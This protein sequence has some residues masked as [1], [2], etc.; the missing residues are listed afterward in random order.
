MSLGIW[1]FTQKH[2]WKA[3]GGSDSDWFGLWRPGVENK[4][5]GPGPCGRGCQELQARG[6]QACPPH[7]L[8]PPTSMNSPLQSSP[9]QSPSLVPPLSVVLGFEPRTSCWS[10]SSHS[11]P[12]PLHA[13]GLS[14]CES[15]LTAQRSESG[16][17]TKERRST[18]AEYTVFLCKE[19]GVRFHRPRHYF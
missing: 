2:T 11:S 14:H 19:H 3:G 4:P 1:I 6:P 18:G 10:G 8:F 7:I 13:Q 15:Y 12:L 17:E 16:L 5:E 9:S